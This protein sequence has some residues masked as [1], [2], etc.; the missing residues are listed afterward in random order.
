VALKNVIGIDHAVVV[1]R[2][3]DKAAENW[4]R[5]GFTMSARG[6]HSA[7]MGSGNYTIMLDPDYI[8]LLGVL[9]ETEHNAPTR[10]FLAKRGEGI[11]RIAFT[12][13]DSA[14]GT[15]EIRA[16]G[17]E[18]VGPVDFE[19]PVTMP[20]G[21]LSAAKF[22]IFQWPIAEAP[23]ALRIFACQHKT[24]ETVWIPELMKHANGAKRLKQVLVVSP[25][26]AKDA[27]HLARMI[28]RDVR[29][30][31]DGAVAVPSGSDRADFIFLAKDQLGRR[32]PEVPLAG[33]PERG[34]A[35]LVLATSDLAAAEKA[36]GSAGVRSGDAVCVV[37]AAANGMLLA[38]LKA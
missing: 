7:K 18:P 32:Y 15:E 29:T 36:V 14:A 13:V 33:L 28:D 23:G 27:A 2:D 12:A 4:K 31:V 8:E 3:L 9:V 25:E 38:F 34:G 19:R 30:E 22:R 1:V 17:Y 24:R 10:A 5:L 11:E 16:R 37:P 35:G 20:D 6:T 21:S 26:A